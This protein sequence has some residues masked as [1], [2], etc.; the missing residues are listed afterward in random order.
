MFKASSTH[1]NYGETIAIL[2]SYGSTGNDAISSPTFVSSPSSSIAP[3]LLST[4]K[5]L[6]NVSGA[7]GSIQ[8]KW[9]RS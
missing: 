7:G 1:S 3:K 5:A 8:S 6:I 9:T 4:S 2:A